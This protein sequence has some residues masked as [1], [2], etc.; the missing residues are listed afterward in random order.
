IGASVARHAVELVRVSRPRDES[1]PEF[2]QKYVNYGARVRAAQF[3]GL[4]QNARA[5]MKGLYHVT[6]DDIRA[7]YIPVLRHRILLNFHADSDRLRQDDILKKVL[8]WKGV[9]RD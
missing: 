6:Y 5:L 3:L 9:P 1:A 2:V 7:L 4:Y 8:E